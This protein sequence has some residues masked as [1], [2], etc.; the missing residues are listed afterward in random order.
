MYF[1]NFNTIYY[2]FN[3]G[4]ELVIKLMTDITQNVRVAN[5]TLGRLSFYDLYDIKEGETPDIVANKLYNDSNFHWTLMVSNE[6]FDYSTEWPLSASALE[7]YTYEKY[8]RFEATT[9][10]YDQDI[11]TVNVPGHNIEITSLEDVKVEN[12]FV[13]INGVKQNIPALQ[14]IVTL[15]DADPQAGTVTLKAK[16]NVTGTPIAGFTFYTYDREYGTIH[17]YEKDGV[18]VDETTTGAQPVYCNEY[19]VRVNDS[20]RQI[21]VIAP[22]LIF[23]FASDF[24][25]YLIGK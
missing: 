4:S 3:I 1:N 16:S 11:V 25:N 12:V 13:T 14:G 5:D 22:N 20:K 6:I 8:N 17:H 18:I 19:E 2:G 24:Q 10:S 7:K 21:K 23:E 9:W 15:L